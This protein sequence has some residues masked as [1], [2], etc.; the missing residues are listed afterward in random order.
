MYIQAPGVGDDRGDDLGVQID[1]L[2]RPGHGEVGVLGHAARDGGDGLDG[3]AGCVGG[4]LG[5]SGG[6]RRGIGR[7]LG[8]G[9][10]GGRVL[11]AHLPCGLGGGGGG[12]RVLGAHLPCGLGGGG[13]GGRV[14]GAHLPCGLSGSRGGIRGRLRDGGGARVARG[15]GGG[16]GIGGGIGGGLGGSGR[17]FGVIRLRRFGRQGGGRLGGFGGAARGLGRVA[18]GLRRVA[19]GLRRGRGVACRRVDRRRVDGGGLVVV[20]TA[21]QREAGCTNAG[22][23]AGS[24]HGA[25]RDLSLSQGGPVVPAAHDNPLSGF[26][27]VPWWDRSVHEHARS[28]TRLDTTPPHPPVMSN[29]LIKVTCV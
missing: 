19:R 14:L 22:F 8:G 13:G 1:L 15:P 26:P 9:G 21:D 25:T 7:G 17:L 4:L 12:G 5:G 24:Q 3:P 16:G 11:G 10:G 2:E 6:D 29:L 28:L 18:R 23:G 27:A 20:A